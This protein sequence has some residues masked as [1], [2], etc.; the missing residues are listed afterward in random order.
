[1]A[2]VD[3]KNLSG[4][5]VGT[6]ELADAVFAAEV[7]PTLLHETTRWYLAAQRSGTHKVKRRGEVEGSGKKLWRQKGTGR[8][9]VGSVRSPIWRKG[10]TVHG[11]VPRDYSYRI[12][13]KVFAGALR[14]ALSTKLAE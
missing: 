11:P 9:R 10:G 13:R 7:N 14:S 12:P 3:V 8:A 1:M 5:T 6:V 2:V 4:E